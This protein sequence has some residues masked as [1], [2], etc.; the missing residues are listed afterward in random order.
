MMIDVNLD[1]ALSFLEM[2]LQA[3][4]DRLDRVG[5]SHEVDLVRSEFAAAKFMVE[6]LCGPEVKRR[7]LR[8]LREKGFKIPHCGLRVGD[9]RIGFTADWDEGYLGWDSDADT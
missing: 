8:Q 9:R 2:T 7:L 5:E 1:S 6:A 4:Y 3:Y